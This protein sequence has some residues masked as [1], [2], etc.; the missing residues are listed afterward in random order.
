MITSGALLIER[1]TPRPRLFEVEAVPHPDGWMFVRPILTPQQVEKE[2]S[3][4]G[5][6]FFF[7][8]G[9]I[10]TTALAFNR[11]KAVD[12]ALKRGIR[13]VKQQ[14]CNCLQVESVEMRSFLGIPYIRMSVRPRHIQKGML[15]AG[16]S[17]GARTDISAA[18]LPRKVAAT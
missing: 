1:D 9:P 3:A 6:T 18:E 17:P 7:M 2:L 10:R 5:W 15:F 4:T 16:S 13:A 14:G 12:A 11:N 8:A